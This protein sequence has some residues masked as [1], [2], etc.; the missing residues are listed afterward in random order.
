MPIKQSSRSSS[1]CTLSFS[2]L[3]KATTRVIRDVLPS[4]DISWTRCGLKC[5]QSN[6]LSHLHIGFIIDGNYS[7]VSNISRDITTRHGVSKDYYVITGRWISEGWFD[8]DH[9]HFP[10][11]SLSLSL[12]LSLTLY[13]SPHP[14]LSLFLSLLHCYCAPYRLL[15][16]RWKGIVSWQ[17]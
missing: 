10:S 11:S 13:I 3:W 15:Y 7:R 8:A 9:Y 6:L 12:T 16:K 17:W 1:K 5:R 2:L 14:S 4:L